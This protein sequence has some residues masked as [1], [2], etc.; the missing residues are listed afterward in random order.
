MTI[1]KDPKSSKP[2]PGRNFSVYVGAG[3]L[4]RLDAEAVKQDRSRSWIITAAVK[5]YLDGQGDPK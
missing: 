1:K 3:L 2:A 4:V 5:R